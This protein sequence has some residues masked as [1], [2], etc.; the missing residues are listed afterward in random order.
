M[1]S[2]SH[3]SIRERNEYNENTNDR[4]GT[5]TIE[6]NER[7]ERNDEERVNEEK[8]KPW[9]IVIQN[10]KGLI[11]E[12]SKEKVEL[13]KEYTEV[14]NIILMN[15]TETWCDDTVED[16]VEIEGYNIYRGD[17]KEIIR[18]GTAIYLHDKL[19]A[20]K[21]CEISY[22]KCDMVAIMIPEIQ[23]LNIVIYRP[24]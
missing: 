14:D 21:I 24:P 1:G 12:T 7:N 16:V 17:R 9:K 8:E 20:N 11:T 13:L 23:T 18:G 15:I 10:M 19:E 3:G 22:Q 6:S 2:N 5:E 4:H